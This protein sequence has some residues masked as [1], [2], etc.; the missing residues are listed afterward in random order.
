MYLN[1]SR[2]QKLFYYQEYDY[3]ISKHFLISGNYFFNTSKNTKTVPHNFIYLPI[4]EN[5]FVD[6]IKSNFDMRN[7]CLD[8]NTLI[9]RRNSLIL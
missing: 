8:Q 2:Y 5:G 9:A 1:L 3:F 4:S 7:F 6:S